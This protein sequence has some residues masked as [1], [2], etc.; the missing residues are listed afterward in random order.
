MLSLLQYATTAPS[1]FF[2][3]DC[4]THISLIRDV[5]H[6]GMLPRIYKSAIEF[7]L[8]PVLELLTYTHSQNE[9]IACYLYP[10]SL[11]QLQ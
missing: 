9:G 4:V 10:Y 11:V 6:S 2:Q 7:S 8:M 3:F 5:H 1:I